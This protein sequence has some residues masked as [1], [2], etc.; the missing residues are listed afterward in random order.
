MPPSFQ[1]SKKELP[2]RAARGRTFTARPVAHDPRR[3]ASAPDFEGR[4]I[5]LSRRNPLR[6]RFAGRSSQR[7]T[8]SDMTS[9]RSRAQRTRSPRIRSARSTAGGRW[10]P[11]A[12]AKCPPLPPSLPHAAEVNFRTQGDLTPVAQQAGRL[13][14]RGAAGPP[15]QTTHVVGE[16]AARKPAGPVPRV[17]PRA[18]RLACGPQ[19]PSARKAHT[20]QPRRPDHDERRRQAARTRLSE[21]RP[22]APL[23][24][25]PCLVAA[26]IGDSPHPWGSYSP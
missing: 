4:R 12:P 10:R 23:L 19:P 2:R 26:A 20:E 1:T 24:A 14:R 25:H 9:A 5:R 11:G 18:A 7:A 13:L 16:A 21:P 22:L 15:E 6:R 8:L 3:R 17:S